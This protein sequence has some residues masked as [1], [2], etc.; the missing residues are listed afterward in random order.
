MKPKGLEA[1]LERLE[2]RRAVRRG[3]LHRIIVDGIDRAEAL[4]RYEQ[5][6][7]KIGTDDLVICRVIVDPVEAGHA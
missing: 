5:E 4:R 2:A 6:G 7:N 3:R 1:R